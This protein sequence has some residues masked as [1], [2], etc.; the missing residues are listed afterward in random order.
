LFQTLD[1]EK[2]PEF[3]K[4]APLIKKFVV[5]SNA[6]AQEKGLEIVTHLIH[7]FTDWCVHGLI[8][9]AAVLAFIESY[10]MAGKYVE[11]VVSGIVT[12]CLISPKVKTREV[13]QEIVLMFVEI[14]KQE[15]VIEELIKGLDNKTPKIVAAVVSLIRQCLNS[16]GVK[17][18]N[19][20]PI[21]KVWKLLF[22][23]FYYN[24]FVNICRQ[25]LDF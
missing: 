17:V 25:F 19:V 12:K 7:T 5:D 16:F 20:K 3:V 2:S 24:I 21:V 8:G 4:Y 9:L 15:L 14:E 13:S 6:A 23:C 11:G 1:D 10:A 22:Q 18:I